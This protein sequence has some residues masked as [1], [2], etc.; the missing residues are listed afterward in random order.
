MS[1][2]GLRIFLPICTNLLIMLHSALSEWP[3]FKPA[4]THEC[5]LIFNTD[6]VRIHGHLLSM[7]IVW[8]FK[9]TNLRIKNLR[10]VFKIFLKNITFT[11]KTNKS[12]HIQ[13]IGTKFT[14]AKIPILWMFPN[15]GSV[16]KRLL[17]WSC[18]E[19]KRPYLNNGL[20][21][22][23]VAQN[24]KDGLGHATAHHLHWTLGPQGH[25]CTKRCLHT[26][27]NTEDV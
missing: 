4:R 26:H 16:T 23:D 3:R 22:E 27:T 2:I 8:H 12:Q 1:E 21:L 18:S 7:I 13:D 15:S 17:R 9:M 10:F 6:H 5:N 24:G 11:N 14:E 20:C 25:H 19:L